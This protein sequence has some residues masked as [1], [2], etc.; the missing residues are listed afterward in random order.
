MEWLERPIN[1][2]FFVSLN[3][4]CVLFMT[5]NGV[6]QVEDQQ[7]LMNLVE[8]SSCSMSIVFVCNL[9]QLL[10]LLICYRLLISLQN[11]VLA[12]YTESS[13]E[14]FNGSEFKDLSMNLY[15]VIPINQLRPRYNEYHKSR[16]N[17][18][19]VKFLL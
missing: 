3:D 17:T 15:P 10:T 7:Q 2:F 14:S 4:K 19:V 8:H 16:Q 9:Y 12:F 18:K 6:R 13:F 11:N 5:V 1:H